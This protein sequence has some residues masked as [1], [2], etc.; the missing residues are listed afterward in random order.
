MGNLKV[1]PWSLRLKRKW[2]WDISASESVS[3]AQ[4]VKQLNLEFLSLKAI[5][6][7]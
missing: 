6:L 2:P 5:P 7:P 4:G 3:G 1:I